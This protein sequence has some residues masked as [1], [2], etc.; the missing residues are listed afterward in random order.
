MYA[1]CC[2]FC[3]GAGVVVVLVLFCFDIVF[4]LH[5]RCWQCRN[6]A[7]HHKVKKVPLTVLQTSLFRTFA[8]QK[9]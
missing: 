1:N 2:K 6:G 9:S 8:K 4:D 3:F 7:P 5:Q